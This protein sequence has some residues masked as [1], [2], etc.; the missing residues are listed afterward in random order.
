MH[1][2]VA[3]GAVLALV[4]LDMDGEGDKKSNWTVWRTAQTRPEGTDLGGKPGCH[5]PSPKIWPLTA[6]LLQ[7]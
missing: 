2:T 5:I 7:L 1:T 6:S 3:Q 4:R